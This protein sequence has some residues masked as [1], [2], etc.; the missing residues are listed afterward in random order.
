VAVAFW[1]RLCWRK[2]AETIEDPHSAAKLLSNVDG[3]RWIEALDARLPRAEAAGATHLLLFQNAGPGIVR[4]ASLLKLISAILQVWQAQREES[5][6]LI[7]TRAISR[8]KIHAENPAS[9]WVVK[10]FEYVG[11]GPNG[12]ELGLG[13][14]E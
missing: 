3:N 6:R 12:A 11:L 14:G 13:F 5:R 9:Y 2:A 4:A 1:A 7:T 8:Q 10:G